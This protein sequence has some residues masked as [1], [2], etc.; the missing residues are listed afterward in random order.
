[1]DEPFV[2]A[3]RLEVI[4]FVTRAVLDLIPVCL[5]LGKLRGAVIP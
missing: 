1:M 2:L 5:E 3:K 4:V